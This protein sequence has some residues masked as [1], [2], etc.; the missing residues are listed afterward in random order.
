MLR[1]HHIRAHYEEGIIPG[2][3]NHLKLWEHHPQVFIQLQGYWAFHLPVVGLCLVTRPPK[4]ACIA[5]RH[6]QAILLCGVGI[7][8]GFASPRVNHSLAHGCLRITL[9]GP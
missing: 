4:V 1:R 3:L 9:F 2:A 8:E 6:L 7:N 5:Y